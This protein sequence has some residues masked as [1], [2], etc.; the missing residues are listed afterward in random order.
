MRKKCNRNDYE[1]EIYLHAIGNSDRE[2]V[3]LLDLELKKVSH[4]STYTTK[5][6][7]T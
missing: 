3:G 2:Q 1:H 4:K 7:S 5:K 6:L